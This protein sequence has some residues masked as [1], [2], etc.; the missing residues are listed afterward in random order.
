[1]KI[2]SRQVI[3]ISFIWAFFCFAE[4]KLLIM[5]WKEEKIN[6]FLSNLV[7]N[8]KSKD[9]SHSKKAVFCENGKSLIVCHGKSCNLYNTST[10]NLVKVLFQCQ[11]NIISH[12]LHPLELTL[13]IAVTEDG[14]VTVFN[15]QTN[16]VEHSTKLTIDH[17]ILNEKKI[18]K[19]DSLDEKEKKFNWE[20]VELNS[21]SCRKFLYAETKPFQ[22]NSSEILIW[23]SWCLNDEIQAHVSVFSLQDG[24]QNPSFSLRKSRLKKSYQNFA[25]SKSQ[26]L[27]LFAGISEHCLHVVFFQNKNSYIYSA[28]KHYTGLKNELTC[29]AFHPFENC[30]ATGDSMGRITIWKNFFYKYPLKDIFHWHAM[31]VSDLTFSKFGNYIFSGGEENVLVKWSL[32]AQKKQFLPRL[33][34]AICSLSEAS[35]TSLLSVLTSDSRILIMDFNFHVISTI[36]DFS[37][38]NTLRYAKNV[39]LF[40]IDP[41]SEAIVL[42]GK[43]GHIQFLSIKDEGKL[44]YTFDVTDRNFITPHCTSIAANTEVTH[45]IFSVTGEWLITAENRKENTCKESRLKFWKYINDK[46]SFSLNTNVEFPHEG[47]EIYS[48]EISS[49]GVVAT[50]GPDKK[51]RLWALSDYQTGNA[52]K[53]VWSLYRDRKYRHLPCFAVDFSK[54]SSLVAVSF[55]SILTIWETDS[56]AL[57]CSLSSPSSKEALKVCKFG[58]NEWTH[59]VVT[60]TD[61]SVSCWNTITLSLVWSVPLKLSLLISD[62]SSAYMASFSKDQNLIVF[63]PSSPSPKLVLK[64]VSDSPVVAATC[65]SNGS[66]KFRLF[67]LNTNQDLFCLEGDDKADVT[68][69]NYYDSSNATPYTAQMAQVQNSSISST[70]KFVPVLKNNQQ[71]VSDL[72][73]A[74]AHTLPNPSLLCSQVLKGLLLFSIA[75]PTSGTPTKVETVEDSKKTS[76]GDENIDGEINE[77]EDNLSCIMKTIFV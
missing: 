21:L 64:N 39:N 2:I 69:L 60:G 71:F 16:E 29:I 77:D 75:K 26:E 40:T 18:S 51:F 48:L 19:F 23:T 20:S 30:I 37:K 76:T 46:A 68:T 22:K 1:M 6:L 35:E 5:G 67:F 12:H 3:F 55:G 58:N 24:K 27:D 34:S 61:F 43:T 66:E 41:R 74:P 42:N 59:L 49:D 11:S 57:K 44:M 13:V 62:P 31:A 52:T 54:D 63:N 25:L 9:S 38:W 50:T 36:Q 56:C 14:E 47:Y 8:K 73:N 65:A 4:R 32:I 7:I 33:S 17:T 53:E 70:K 15:L 72:L 28:R 10:G 45:A